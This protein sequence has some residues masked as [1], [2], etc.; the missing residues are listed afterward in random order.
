VEPLGGNQ[1]RSVDVRVIA[2]T[3]RNLAEEVQEDR[4]RQDLYFR[5]NV[6]PIEV[7]PLRKRSQDVLLLA[8][9][10][11]QRKCKK[12][13]KPLATLSP[14]ATQELMTYSWPGNVRELEHAL[15]RAIL[16]CEGNKIKTLNIAHPTAAENLSI[17][18]PKAL[19]EV[20]R[21]HIYRTL[22]YCKGRIRGKGGAAELL[23]IHPNTLDAKIK[24]LGIEKQFIIE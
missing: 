16:L 19:Q 21:D 10:T 24:K 15:E 22:Q 4:F 7:P 9:S 17:Y 3:N 14:S 12:I 1:V 23:N 5:L 6:L 8:Q 2:A 20:E 11:I 18:V 13:G